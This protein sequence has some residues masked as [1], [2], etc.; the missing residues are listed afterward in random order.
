L[1]ILT[2]NHQTESEDPNGGVRG[3]SEGDEGDCNPIKRITI[4]TNWTLP[5]EIPGTKPPTKEYMW[6]DPWFQLHM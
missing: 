6:R 3:R 2:T 4:S 1:E 5:S